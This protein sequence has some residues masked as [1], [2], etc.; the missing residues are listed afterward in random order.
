MATVIS[1]ATKAMF[2]WHLYEFGGKKFQQKDGGPIGLRGTCAIAHA[3]MQIFDIKWKGFLSQLKLTVWLNARYMDDGRTFLPPVRPGWRM[4]DG[5]LTYCKQ[6]EVEDQWLTGAE[7]TRRVIEATM[8]PVEDYLS[9][10]TE[11]GE[12]FEGGW[13][14]T[15]DTSIKVGG[16]E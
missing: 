11:I 9:F 14:P 10:T 16:T 5:K 15:L 4:E 8:N 7:R 12:Q 13:L 1:L 6:W 3:A 2:N